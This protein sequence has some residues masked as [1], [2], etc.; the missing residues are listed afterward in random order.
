MV[1]QQYLK[2]PV[3]FCS[4]YESLNYV[5]FL[6]NCILYFSTHSAFRLEL[7]SNL[8]EISL[9]WDFVYLC[10]PTESVL[11]GN[12]VENLDFLT[13]ILSVPILLMYRKRVNLCLLYYH[14]YIFSY[15]MSWLFCKQYSNSWR[16]QCRWFQCSVYN[17]VWTIDV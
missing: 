15:S 17:Q 10:Q 3:I 8:N 9:V 16:M 2:S 4:N 5:S 1:F 11:C 14:L 7:V 13:F 6:F 12:L